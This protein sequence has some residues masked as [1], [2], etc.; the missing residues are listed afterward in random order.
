[1]L[2][3]FRKV[4]ST[5]KVVGSAPRRAVL[6]ARWACQNVEEQL[7]DG[8]FRRRGLDTAGRDGAVYGAEG[9]SFGYVPTSWRVLREVFPHGSVSPADVLLDY[10]SGKGRTAIWVAARFQLRRV[11]GVD[12]DEGAQKAAQENLARWQGRLRCKSVQF[13]C[14]DATEFEVPD[15]V[16][17]VYFYNPFGGDVFDRALGKVRASLARRPRSL[18]VI[19]VYPLMHEAVLAAGFSIERQR[20]NHFWVETHRSRVGAEEFS[21]WLLPYEWTIYRS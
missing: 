7:I 14:A 1:M 9:H 8:Y 4:W 15:D 17:I 19:Y 16:S 21:A 11:I 2:R 20:T 10:G 13:I 6:L 3:K 12:V 5:T 18:Q